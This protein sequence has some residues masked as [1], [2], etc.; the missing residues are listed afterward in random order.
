MSHTGLP[1]AAPRA[2]QLLLLTLLALCLT[3]TARAD[4]PEQP[5]FQSLNQ[6]ISDP[7]DSSWAIVQDR[8]GNM[9]FGGQNGLR[10]YDGH[11]ITLFHAGDSSRLAHNW[12]RAM[13]VDAAGRLWIG[14]QRGLQRF[15]PAT[16]TFVD[17]F[18]PPAVV[19][20]S[21]PRVRALV[22]DGRGI[23]WIDPNVGLY[24]RDARSGAVQRLLVIDKPA[25]LRDLALDRF[26]RLW[27]IDHGRVAVV[28][29]GTGQIRWFPLPGA[30]R[31]GAPQAN[32]FSVAASGDDLWVGTGAGLLHWSLGG[33]AMQ[34]P[35]VQTFDGGEVW[36]L[37]PGRNGDL[38]IG[39][40][41]GLFHRD[42]AGRVDSYRHIEADPHSIGDQRIDVLYLD[43][44]G[45]LWISP[46]ASSLYTLDTTH[47]F[48]RHFRTGGGPG[49]LSSNKITHIRPAGAGRIWVGTMDAGLDLVD[50]AGGTV[51][52]FRHDPHQPAT[53]RSDQEIFLTMPD[54]EGRVW[55]STANG[56]DRFEPRDASF[57]RVTP[58]AAAGSH[59]L[60]HGFERDRQGMLWLATH[61]GLRKI[62]PVSGATEELPTLPRPDGHFAPQLIWTM[63]IDPGGVLWLGSTGGL[64]RFDPL[65]ERC[66]MVDLPELRGVIGALMP[67]ADGSLWAGVD[68]AIVHLEQEHGQLR[69]TARFQLDDAIDAILAAPDGA[70]WVST[71]G[72][73]ARVD[74][75]RGTVRRF[76]PSDGLIDVS[77]RNGAALRAEDGTLYFGGFSAGMTSFRP[78]RIAAA[79]PPTPVLTDV[80]LS[81]ASLLHGTLPAG[82][83]LVRAGAVPALTLPHE[84]S[85]LRLDFSAMSFADPARTRYAVQLVGLDQ[86]PTHGAAPSAG[87]GRLPPGDYRL[88]VRA[89]GPDGVWGPI[90]PLLA[91]RVVPPWW[92]TW[93]F[94]LA[95]A[96]AL[97]L[98]AYSV[99][100]LRVRILLRRQRDLQLLV[101]ERTAQLRAALEELQAA[102]R[103]GP[104][105]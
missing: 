40:D 26:G 46:I 41:I 5:R 1:R 101:D 63:A 77:Y 52:N 80:R 44:R 69:V 38:W 42:R 9:W 84:H 12:I 60:V 91:I 95:A 21:A 72:G 36:R 78:E 68:S 48:R 90:A 11:R 8:D 30:D 27:M 55:I 31:P 57:H 89:A 66:T 50:P 7:F 85:G 82:A 76:F 51:K 18:L 20:A 73:M 71:D 28:E 10:R 75:A 62:D 15:D 105:A 70:L 93:W 100:S 19:G 45:M 4:L 58:E 103:T 97:L 61:T 17:V 74:P 56:I 86:Q 34:A 25:G 14:T 29:P 87:Y 22:G 96:L 39:T 67:A 104:V 81:E 99:Y 16:D 43:R 3:S 83:Q 92:M 23:W 35:T 53:L 13:H 24:F 37:L 102:Q 33:E 79:P 54:G 88:H 94:A 98:I 2:L 65:T 59:V 47:G 32:V 49:Q 64:G 6:Q